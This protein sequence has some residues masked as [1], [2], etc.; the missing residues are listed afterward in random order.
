MRGC[1][2]ATFGR[3]L[4]AALFAVL[5]WTSI[6]HAD[7]ALVNPSA[8]SLFK[9]GRELMEAQR[10]PE[11]C[12]KFEESYRLDASAGTL[13]NLG[14]CNE[15]RGKTATAWS[16]YKRTITLG[17]ATNKPR[18]VTAAQ[19]FL[20]AV[21]AK[22]ARVVV[23]ASAPVAGLT[24]R[25]GEVDIGEAARGVPLPFD[26]GPYD[27][28][29]SAPGYEPFKTTVVA[30]EGKTETVTVPAL[31][32]AKAITVRLE[33]K[34]GPPPAPG[35]DALFF[36]GVGGA[37]LGVV[38]LAIGTAFGVMTLDA[39]D[40]A[41]TN[42]ALCPDHACTPRGLEHI[43]DTRTKSQV[44]SGT[45]AAGGALLAAGVTLMVVRASGRGGIENVALVPQLA[46]DGTLAGSAL[47][48]SW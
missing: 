47:V 10:F 2:L 35:P 18:H 46:F 19:E 26:P 17:N 30:T 3:T 11:A 40:E 31:R 20:E 38:G 6:A 32:K 13:L 28:V 12:A 7:D 15:A 33:P 24:L 5:V 37:G 39:A 8:D 42:P 16:L 45:L 4:A 22:L 34:I 23:T 29:A 48:G 27:V 14:R 21:D 25:C 36:L 43:E 44:S 9:A 41:L 1:F